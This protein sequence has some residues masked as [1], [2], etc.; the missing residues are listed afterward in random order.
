MIGRR[1]LALTG[2]GLAAGMPARAQELPDTARLREE[3]MARERLIWANLGARDRPAMRRLLP[4]DTVQIY[5]DGTRYYKSELLAHL[6][7]YRLDSY[8]IE[9]T[10]AVRMISPDVATLLY[11]VT[12]R[13][14]ERFSRTETTK[15]LVSSL[16]AQRDGKWWNVLYH[17]TELKSER[18]GK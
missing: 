4:E 1:S 8:E 3:L 16:Y 6:T 5:A 9:P 14:A 18:P 17:E 12:S 13:G 7:D 10:Y 2:L 15:V 11:R